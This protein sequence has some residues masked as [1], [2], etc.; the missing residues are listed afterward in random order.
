MRT[1]EEKKNLLK[2]ELMN[3]SLKLGELSEK[4]DENCKRIT[5]TDAFGKEPQTL[6]D[7]LASIRKRFNTF[8]E[9]LDAPFKIAVVG[10]QGSGKSTL[11]NL[12]LGEAIMPSS[13]YENEQ[14]VIR[15]AYPPNDEMDGKAILELK[16]KKKK[17]MTIDE[18]V[19]IIDKNTAKENNFNE[20]IKSIISVS[21]YKKHSLLEEI[22]IINTPGMNVITE[23]FY[24]KIR[25]LFAKAD[26]IIW[27]N[28]GEKILGDFNNW[29]I[30]KIYADNKKIIG[31]ITFADKLYRMDNENGVTDVVEQFMNE[32]EN[33]RLIR[34]DNEEIALFIF[35]GKFAQIANGQN[36]KAKF[37][38]DIENL[39]EDEDKLHMIYNYLHHGFA[40]SDMPEN[41]KKLTKFKLY[42]IRETEANSIYEK[43]FVIKDFFE[44]CKKEKFFELNEE[45]RIAI[46]TDKGRAL[47]REVSQ[48]EPF[49]RF[50]EKQL[51][52]R[53]LGEK[54]DWIRDRLSGVLSVDGQA[55]TIARRM[56][57][58]KELFGQEYEELSE[59][60]KNEIEDFNNSLN[61]LKKEYED[62]YENQLE[63]N[64]GK[65]VDDFSEDLIAKFEKEVN[66]RE[67][68]K[69]I[70]S[71][72]LNIF[73]KNKKSPISEQISNI[74]A[75]TTEET[76]SEFSKGLTEEAY[77]KIQQ[78]IIRE[79]KNI[80]FEKNETEYKL[81][82][83][84][85]NRIMIGVNIGDILGKVLKSMNMKKIIKVE[86]PKLAAKDLRKGK[87]TI[88]KRRFVKPLVKSIRKLLRKIGVDWTKK[89][90]VKIS[91]K[92]AAESET[93]PLAIIL[94]AYNIMS[95]ANDIR[96]MYK[97][98]K[99]GIKKQLRNESNFEDFFREEI[100]KIYGNV[101]DF[102]DWQ[103]R[104]EF[105]KNRKDFSN[106]EDCLMACDVAIDEMNKI[107]I[108][109][110]EVE[111]G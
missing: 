2:Q 48:F 105:K 58:I 21:F 23:D 77:K 79:R 18:A 55:D 80:I 37:V 68:V 78:I 69:E 87:N 101:H 38:S 28:S 98:M 5:I 63:Y 54:Y 30:G 88:F 17:E 81:D 71:S 40:Y 99:E 111:N 104:E 53:A 74:I 27:V 73:R 20:F 41:V 39:D 65:Y 19:K 90:A 59:K 25:G 89:E 60:E 43:D 62:W 96:D 36:K 86:L 29:L 12:L 15:I 82:E 94:L 108:K 22:E 75:Q 10:S 91:A 35:N 16:D 50:A 45:S 52:T 61:I 26:I 95:A 11:V 7:L 70:L 76:F 92:S 33:N 24:P 51:E 3:V 6:K 102:A 109:L 47:L 85:Q 31:I 46:Y 67:F 84:P 42:E 56:V 97:K 57:Q 64:A 44:Y 106:I 93:G 100:K 1:I 83:I 110:E 34:D 8:V 9:E 107:R 72:A 13:I 14:A 32:V 103:L 4:V 49:E 66:G